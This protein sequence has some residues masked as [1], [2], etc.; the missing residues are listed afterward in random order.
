MWNLSGF[1][2]FL[3]LSWKQFLSHWDQDVAT[4][5]PGCDLEIAAKG[6]ETHSGV[7]RLLEATGIT[8]I[9]FGLLSINSNIGHGPGKASDL[10]QGPCVFQLQS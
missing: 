4:Y 6:I 9:C 10:L 8:G 3:L 5:L 7:L 1:A 2:E